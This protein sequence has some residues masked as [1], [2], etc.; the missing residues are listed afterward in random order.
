MGRWH[1]PIGWRER[2]EGEGRQ[3]GKGSQVWRWT[4]KDVGSMKG[5]KK[6]WRASKNEEAGFCF[7]FFAHIFLLGGLVSCE[8]PL[9]QLFS[10]YFFSYLFW[11]MF[12]KAHPLPKS[13]E[14]KPGGFERRRGIWIEGKCC[15]GPLVFVFFFQSIGVK[16]WL[17]VFFKQKLSGSSVADKG[18]ILYLNCRFSTTKIVAPVVFLKKNCPDWTALCS[19]VLL[20]MTNVFFGIQLEST[21]W[22]CRECNFPNSD[23]CRRCGRVRRAPQ[24]RKT[25]N[26][27]FF[28]YF[29]SNG[30]VG[31]KE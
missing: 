15:F 8:R 5:G 18:H 9:G 2:K 12:W 17:T 20:Y 7:D 24:P 3:W 6:E 10:R 19:L 1:N 22:A 29:P 21:P 26:R 30:F 23:K 13:T 11:W 25:A 27:E 4:K 14:R 28:R 16:D 31:L